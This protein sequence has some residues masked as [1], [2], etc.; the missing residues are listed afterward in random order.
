MFPGQPIADGATHASRERMLEFFVR[1]TYRRAY[2]TAVAFPALGWTSLAGAQ[3]APGPE[4]VRVVYS[5][6]SGCPSRAELESELAARLGTT[7]LT[8]L[9]EL[10]RTLTIAV[11]GAPGAFRASLELV[12]RDGNQTSREVTAPT[13]DQ[14]VDAIAL[15]AALAVRSQAE[16]TARTSESE[17]AANAAPLAGNTADNQAQAPNTSSQALARSESTEA[18]APPSDGSGSVEG[19]LFA[20]LLLATGVGPGAAPGV[21]LGGR[22]GVAASMGHSVVLSGIV[23]D[24]LERD[25]EAATARF[26]VIKGRLELCPFEPLLTSSLRLCP[27]AGFEAGSHSGQTYADGERVADADSASRLWLG[28]TLAVRLRIYAD[29]LAVTLGP[30]L[31]VPITSNQFNLSQPERLLYEVPSLAVGAAA[32]AGFVW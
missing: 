27:C 22:F 19:E 17:S 12:D 31:L 15:V 8:G 14:A 3:I 29:S 24:T 6:P 13:C 2:A 10:A 1:T 11:D 20:G 30:E 25:Y 28:A 9:D 32:S 23:S 26:G 18:S 5:A 16:R 7:N 21:T 4:A